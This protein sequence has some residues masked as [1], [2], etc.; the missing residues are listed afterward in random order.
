MRF[1][2]LALLSIPLVGCTG[3]ERARTNACPANE[4]CSSATPFGLHFI[5]DEITGVF[6]SNFAGPPPTAVGGTQAVE[7]QYDRNGDQGL[8]PL[9]LPYLTDD[10]GGLGVVVDHT[11]GP[12]VTLRGAGNGSNYLR[13]L[14]PDDGTLYDRKQLAGVA[15]Q[16]IALAPTNLNSTVPAGIDLAWVPG[17]PIG[18][19]LIGEAQRLVDDSM[20]LAMPTGER[21][22]WD[23][24]YPA[25][26]TVGTYSLSVPAGDRP[27]TS[28]DVVI[29]DHA[30]AVAA[31]EPPSAI[32]PGTTTELCFAPTS[33]GRFI[34]GLT[35]M[36][37]VGDDLPIETKSNCV[38]V[39][40]PNNA[41]TLTVQA[42]AGGQSTT[43]TLPVAAPASAATATASPP[44]G[45]T[46]SSTAGERAAR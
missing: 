42:S 24:M 2:Y 31:I 14:D 44:H 20:Q 23:Q 35:W 10:D 41:S 5:G 34:V 29:V 19:A 8:V 9:D 36:I 30:D 16:S 12:V 27:A 4:Q 6:E 7:L 17:E 37:Q 15:I 1:P 32:A 25:D 11:G 38:Y 26:E 33:A 13:I 28:F 3:G 43:I 46:A 22:A 39:S 40:A 18:I 21:I 45:A